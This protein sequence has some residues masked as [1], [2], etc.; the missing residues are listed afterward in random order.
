MAVKLFTVLRALA[1]NLKDHNAG[2]VYKLAA[3]LVVQ[4]AQKL[5]AVI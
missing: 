5:V 2:G 4:W 1:S 3:K